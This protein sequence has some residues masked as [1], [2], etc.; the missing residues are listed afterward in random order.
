M[1]DNGKEFNF[2]EA[3]YEEFV[4][5]FKTVEERVAYLEKLE[6]Q[7]KKSIAEIRELQ[8]KTDFRLD[9]IAAQLDHIT[10]LTGFAFQEI[11]FQNGK[12]EDAGAILSKKKE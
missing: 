2:D 11:E 10:Q 8:A 3:S 12:L 9:R 6:F 4:E 1:S 7:H 5:R